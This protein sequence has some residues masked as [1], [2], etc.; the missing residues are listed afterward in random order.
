[1]KLR[2]R[3]VFRERS[4]DNIHS[5]KRRASLLYGGAFAEKPRNKLELGYVVHALRGLAVMG[6]P[7]KIKPRNSESLFV[8]HLITIGNFVVKGS[9][10]IKI[11]CFIGC[12]RTH[13]IFPPIYIFAGE[14]SAFMSNPPERKSKPALMIDKL[15]V[16]QFPALISEVLWFNL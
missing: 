3:Q 7:H 11:L 9:S 15:I 13:K 8:H 2:H 6:V 16:A 4:V 12:S 5:F 14:Y 10:E 1:M